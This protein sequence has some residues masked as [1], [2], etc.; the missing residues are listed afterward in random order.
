VALL[1]SL[2]VDL[3]EITGWSGDEAR[4]VLAVPG[5]LDEV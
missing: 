1:R 3:L 5:S 4:E 2:V